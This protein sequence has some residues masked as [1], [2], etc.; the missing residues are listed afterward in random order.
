MTLV[1][2]NAVEMGPYRLVRVG[3]DAVDVR[4]VV[5]PHMMFSTPM[6]ALAR[7]PISS[8]IYVPRTWR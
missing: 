7:M 4:I 3:P 2:G 8:W 5:P 1:V 6:S